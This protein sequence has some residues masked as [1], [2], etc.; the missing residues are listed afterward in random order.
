M[1]CKSW[2][3]EAEDKSAVY[4][5]PSPGSVRAPASSPAHR[6]TAGPERC[7]EGPRAQGPALVFWGGHNP[8]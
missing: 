8:C 5:R 1:G 6:L 7:W 4:S 2:G 3:D